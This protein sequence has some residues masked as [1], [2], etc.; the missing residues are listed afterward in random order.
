MSEDSENDCCEVSSDLFGS[1]REKVLRGLRSEVEKRREKLRD[2]AGGVMCGV[3]KAFQEKMIERSSS[4]GRKVK[5]QSVSTREVREQYKRMDLLMTDAVDVI[6]G[7]APQNIAQMMSDRVRDSKEEVRQ[8]I[9]DHLENSFEGYTAKRR[10]TDKESVKG[11]KKTVDVVTS[12]DVV[13]EDKKDSEA[14]STLIA[15][16]EVSV[17]VLSAP[18]DHASTSESLMSFTAKPG[19]YLQFGVNGFA[20]GRDVVFGGRK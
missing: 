1:E 14:S 13:S 6:T 5:N 8:T 12:V 11:R 16:M 19:P 20:H 10:K 7:E 3:N 2:Y 15:S 9:D 4:L 17:D 18:G